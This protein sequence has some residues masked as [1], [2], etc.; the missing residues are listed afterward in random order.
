MAAGKESLPFAHVERERPKN[1]YPTNIRER[2]MSE[3]RCQNE[4]EAPCIYMQ[5]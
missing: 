5:H 2:K 3:M 1:V 4:E